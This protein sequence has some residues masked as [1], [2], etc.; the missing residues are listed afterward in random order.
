MSTVQVERHIEKALR[1]Q[2]E[3][4]GGKCFKWVSPSNNGVTDRI[5][6]VRGQV[7]FVELKKPRGSRTSALQVQFGEW[8]VGQ[9]QNYAKI[10]NLEQVFKLIEKIIENELPTKTLPD[11]R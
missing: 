7:W 11:G 4:L 1:T 9:G 10:Q 8:L 5:C 2:V 6:I 3:K